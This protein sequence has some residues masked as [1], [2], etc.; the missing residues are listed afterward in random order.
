MGTDLF[1]LIGMSVA[2]ATIA[3][4]S[5]ILAILIVTERRQ[6]RRSDAATPPTHTV[7]LLRRFL[8]I[9]A[10]GGIVAGILVALEFSIFFTIVG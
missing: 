5:V 1:Q 6:A 8:T 3:F 10:V 7:T 2:I 4:W 9:A